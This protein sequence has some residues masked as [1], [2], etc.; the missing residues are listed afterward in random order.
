MTLATYLPASTRTRVWAPLALLCVSACFLDGGGSGST[1]GITGNGETDAS[2]GAT[3]TGVSA[4]SDPAGT[5]TG[6]DSSTSAGPTTTNDPT[7]PTTDSTTDPTDPTTNPTTDPGACPGECSPGQVEE[8]APCDPCGVETRSCTDQCS[9]GAWS[10][11]DAERCALWSLANGAVTWTTTRWS[12]LGGQPDA[13]TTPIEAAFDATAHQLAVVLTH[14]SFHVLDVPGQQWIDMGARSSLFPQL[15]D[16]T[17]RAAYSTNPG[18]AEQAPV[19]AVE[20]VALLS[21][22][23]VWAYTGFH[24]PTL[25]HNFLFQEPCCNEN[26]NWQVPEAPAPGDLRAYWLDLVGADLWV[27]VQC[28]GT[29]FAF[30]GA[31][32]TD[33]TAH[34]QDIG[35]C[36]D[37]L[38]ETGFSD[39]PPLALPGAPSSGALLGGAF[40]Q[41]KA[42]FLVGANT[43]S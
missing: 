23:S 36:F 11:E 20:D 38:Y 41:G 32:L 18:L 13:P 22:D 25:G 33:T 39:Y 37:F 40:Y 30:Y 10:C 12:E 16:A 43:S 31:A 17:L 26:A 21:A 27:D 14:E 34:V 8:G 28:D 24:A 9:W 29:P 2:T 35:Y 3:S 6:D 15:G 1:Y 4:S 42:I 7:A 19:S 5:S